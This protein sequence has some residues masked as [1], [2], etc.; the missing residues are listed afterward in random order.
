VVYNAS[1]LDLKPASDPMTDETITLEAAAQQLGMDIAEIL[2]LIGA[3]I[4]DADEV[5]GVWVIK[6]ADLDTI[7]NAD[8]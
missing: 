5:D 1:G 8:D 3:G 2:G 4:I 6:L 7:R